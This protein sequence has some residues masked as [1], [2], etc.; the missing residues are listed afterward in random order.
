MNSENILMTVA[1]IAVVVAAL[2]AGFTYYVVNDY[3][4][5]LTGHATSG[6]IDLEVQAAA[7]IN[8]TTDSID[9]GVGNVTNTPGSATLDTAAGTVT[10]GSWTPV[11]EGFVVRNIGNVNLTLSLVTGKN[12]TTFIGGTNPEYQY[13]VT[14][15]DAGSCVNSTG[16]DLG[17]YY[18]VNITSPGTRVCDVFQFVDGS[19]RISIDIRL[20]VPSDSLTGALTDTM[21]ASFAAA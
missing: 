14:N 3:R 2:G 7:L 6:D 4:N 1:V 11:S 15:V 16:F 9:W 19:D 17:T 20:V 18:S 12:S 10:G 5:V 13:N 8:F 21:T